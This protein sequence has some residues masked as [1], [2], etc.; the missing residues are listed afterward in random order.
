MLEYAQVS[1][2]IPCYNEQDTI[3][4]LLDALKDQTYPFECM[5]IIIA[6]GMST[7]GTRQMIT[8][9]QQT[10]PGFTVLLIDNQRRVIPSALNRALE[11]A[12]GEIIV[13]LD[14]HS[15]PR[16]DYVQRCVEALQAGKGDNV[17]GVWEI[18]PGDSGWMARSI[19]VAAAHPLGVGDASYRYTTRAGE[20]DTVPFGA[21]RRALVQQIGPYDERLL[22]NEDY[23]FNVRI[24]QA[25]GRVWLD[26][27]IRA[28][29]FARPNLRALM[30]Q[31]WRYGYWK[32]RMLMRYPET[33]RW[34][35]ALPPAF[36]LGLAGLLLLGF[37]LPVMHWVLLFVLLVYGGV[38]L[39]AGLERAARRTDAAL[40]IGVP[41]AILCMHLCWGAAFLW[42]LITLPFKITAGQIADNVIKRDNSS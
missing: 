2:I 30:R 34:R 10:N 41:L 29:Y 16:P 38:L 42:S 4:L 28:T 5:E 7:D 15:L 24:R 27:M 9:W 35:Q 20:V 25:G 31:Y 6:D 21:Y 18:Q 1:I 17:G 11:A 3:H 23:E 19:A 8:T 36:I 40:A 26:P 33:L 22:S 13:R 14:A 37:W 39:A 32:L 12:N